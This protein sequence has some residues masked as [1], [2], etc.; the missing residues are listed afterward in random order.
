MGEL[1]R[2][3]ASSQSC[4]ARLGADSLYLLSL[5][6][7]WVHKFVCFLPFPQCQADFL[8]MLMGHL[9]RLSLG[10]IHRELPMGW[11]TW[12]AG[13]A[14]GPAGGNPQLRC[15]Q[16]LLGRIADGAWDMV[17]WIHAS[18]IPSRSCG[19]YSLSCSPPHSHAAHLS[20]LDGVRS[21]WVSLSVFY[22]AGLEYFLFGFGSA[23]ITY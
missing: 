22:I 19:C 3:Y 2:L 8:H 5:R 1:S 4:R 9:Q 17:N 23:G 15:P 16:Q 12:S 13:S 21:K 14:C 7:C 11:D 20:I 10:G 18:L 6:C